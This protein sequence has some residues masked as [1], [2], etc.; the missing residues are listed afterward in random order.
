V[1]RRSVRGRSLG[2]SAKV[3]KEVQPN[4]SGSIHTQYVTPI[5]VLCQSMVDL[6]TSSQSQHSAAPLISHYHKASTSVTIN[7]FLQQTNWTKLVSP[8]TE[9]QHHAGRLV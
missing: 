8:H 4:Y 6:P 7:H 3:G 9:M 1:V 5:F 2:R